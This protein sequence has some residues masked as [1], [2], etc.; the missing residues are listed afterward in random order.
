M[1]V[2]QKFVSFILLFLL[3]GS[4]VPTAHE[5][6]MSTETSYSTSARA[7]GV[8]LTVTDTSFSYT[9]ASDEEQYR[10]F[11]SNHPVPGFNRDEMIYVVDTVVDVPIQLV[12]MVKNLGTASSG[13]INVNIIALHNEYSF[14]EMLNETVQM[15]ALSGGN[16]NSV[17][18]II[19]PTYSGNHTLVIRVTSAVLDDNAQ[20]DVKTVSFT[21]AST[22]F[23]CDSLVGWTPGTQWGI[24][25]DTALSMGSS[26]HVGNGQSSS[27]TN[28]LATSLVT[29][30]MDMSDAVSNPTRTNGL[31]F[32]YTGSVQ[33]PADVLKI[34][35]LTAMGSWYQLGSISNSIDQNFDD[36]ASYQTFSINHA[37]ATS[38][39]IP[40][41]QEHF[42]SQTQFRF[43]FESDVQFTDIGYYLDELVF[44]YD[45]KVRQ[46]EYALSSNGIST[47]GS[48]AGEWGT[49]SVQITNDGNISDTLLPEI[50]GLPAG[51]DVYF[52]Y[53]SGVSINTQS[54]ILLYPGESKYIDVKFQP[55]LNAT[56][57][58]QQMIFKGSSNQYPEVNTTL[59]MQ[60]QVLPDREPYII[61]PEIAPLCPPG[62]TCPFTIEVQNIGDA[63]DVFDLEIDTSALPQNWDVN[64]AW[65]QDSSV[66]VRQDTPAYVDFS[67][68]MPTDA[69]PDS[70]YSFVLT[71][72][73]QNSSLRSHSLSIEVTASMISNATIVV[74][75]YQKQK[76]LT[77]NAGE[78]V[79][80]DYTIWNN[81]S[82]QDIF[83]VSLL[84]DLPGQWVIELPALNN[85]VINSQSS[86]SFKIYVTAPDTGQA[87]DYAPTIT[88]V[89]K[90]VRSGMEFQGMP[91]DGIIVSI[92]SDLE[93]RLIESPDT[94][95][96]GVPT[97]VLLELENNGNG[98]VSALLSSPTIPEQWDWWMR[99]DNANHSGPIELSAPYDDEDIVLIEV[100]LLLP[101]TEKAEELNLIEF[102]VMNTDGLTDLNINDNAI[103]FESYTESIRIPSLIAGESE[104]TAGV[105]DIVSVN[106]TVKNMGNALDKSFLVSASVST[107]PP[108][109]NITST[110]NI[111]DFE[112]FNSLVMDAG[113][114]VLVEVDMIIPE[115]MPL[116]TRIIV[117]FDVM[118][119]MNS[120]QLPY[121][122]RHEILILVDKQR[123]MQA[124]MS[125]QPEQEFTTGV[126]APFWINLT[127]F[128]TQPEQYMVTVTQPEQWQTV[129]QGILV[130][131]T[132]QQLEHS[133]GHVTQRNTN[134][135]C[136]LH[137]LGGDAN[138]EVTVRIETVD[139]V[140]SWSDSRTFNFKIVE[141]DGFKMNAELIASSLAGI[142]FV[143]VVMTML[144]RKKR[145]QTDSHTQKVLIE[146]SE[147]T[148]SGPP[149]TSFGPPVSYIPGPSPTEDVVR[150]VDSERVSTGP[151]VPLEGLPDG[152]TI[153]QWQYYGQQYLDTKQ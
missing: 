114:E 4:S 1:S 100:W 27:Y 61:A 56:T 139:G 151:E 83:T 112:K 121:E 85:A 31:S 33:F 46:E 113:Q 101:S 67:L 133:A 19:T 96:P 40:I 68:T 52:A 120:E 21:V 109:Q 119:G 116:N 84:Y 57:G 125:L 23:N 69:I 105:G 7:T 135:M 37:G 115:D 134:M 17:S 20:N 99:I 143:A 88:P 152:W 141:S 145:N 82:R 130:N 79:S 58:L 95:T 77:I 64:F 70:R 63:T 43:L 13:N 29:P 26:C 91:Y 117:T 98:H 78:T 8:D 22:Y 53:P 28:N 42:H 106:I 129:C 25:T 142:L 127:S 74:S 103:S 65:T 136:E 48:V 89:L 16:S 45:Q 110:L 108:F 72:T 14:F 150:S 11:S 102:T 59:P 71:A 12:I 10:M 39:L 92:V 144:L 32:F 153:E 90:S 140:L 149:V 87:G 30:V 51:W 36:S 126:P 34:Q 111:G 97:M 5:T 44:V 80:I 9:L 47:I 148:P 60:F 93:L 137:R 50:I 107:S 49:V 118:A 123:K 62:N 66:L 128:S 122:L 81:A 24:S 138:G 41:P 131:E 2:M 147:P 55:D 75:E 15:T 86:T 3:V 124:E 76:D 54:G 132:G 18:K 104:M 35:V 94:L 73:S 146:L 6:E 38:P